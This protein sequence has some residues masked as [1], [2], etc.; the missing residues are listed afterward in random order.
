MTKGIIYYTDNS[1]DEEFAGLFRQRLI[2]A[3]PDIPIVSVSQKPIDFG[4]NICIGEI[5][6]SL[7]TMWKQV[8]TALLYS[9]ADIIYVIEHDVL[10]NSS[11]FDFTPKDDNCFYYNDNIW[12]VRTRDGRA[13][14]KPSLC[15]SQCVCNR[16][17][18]LEDI[19]K[20]VEWCEKGGIPPWH[21]GAYEPGRI[22][23]SR[24]DERKIFGINVDRKWRLEHF[25]STGRPNIDIRHGKNL[26]GMR[27]FKPRPE[28]VGTGHHSERIYADAVP[29]WGTTKDRFDEW[30]REVV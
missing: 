8:L 17:I 6:R 16:L 10:Y 3:A 14:W 15:F 13:L 19:M 11:H 18:L 25:K 26:S 20:R 27:R 12:L 5:G 23:K 2:N 30:I 9:K 29:G 24:L 4:K 21:Q 28:E 1:L 22:R 7:I